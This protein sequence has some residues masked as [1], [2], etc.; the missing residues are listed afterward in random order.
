MYTP[1]DW[2]IESIRRYGL[3]DTED[4]RS[5]W[6]YDTS[7]QKSTLVTEFDLVCNRKEQTDICQSI[8]MLGILIGSVIFGP[9]G[10]RIGRRPV[11]LISILLMFSFGFGAA[12]VEDFYVFMVLRCLVGFATA[13]ILINNLVLVAEWV[14]PSQRAYATITGHVC[15]AVGLMVLAGMGYALRNW[16]L[17]QIA[18]SA[19]SALLVFYIW[20]LPESPRWLLAKGKNEKAKELLQKA[21]HMNKRVLSEDVLQQLQEEKQTKSGNMIDLFRTPTLRKHTLIMCLV[22]FVNA[23][24]YYGLSLSVGNFG[25]DIYLTQL[26]FGAV[27]IPAR[28]GSMFSVQF[29][30]RKLSQAIYLLLGGT[31]CLIIIAI[32]EKLSI[33]ITVL[34]VIGKFA[35]ASSYSVCYIYAA[36]LFPTVIRQNGVG[37]CSMTSRL[38]GIMAPLISI[39]EKYHPAIPMAVYGSGP[40]I[41]GL[42]CFFLPETQG[43]DLQDHTFEDNDIP[44][45]N[46]LPKS[47]LLSDSQTL[48]EGPDEKS[49]RL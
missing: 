27:E 43:R 32:P 4:C 24:V 1:V 26:I 14:G 12:F 21:A 33:V 34:A 30:G 20:L 6:V 18:C 10:D 49:T 23:L 46:G 5:G 31:A 29:F 28:L 7:Q 38:A 25:F 40:I 35:T 11:I 13:G 41:G 9:L 36:E 17:L 2:D 44:R 3:N 48:H 39:L 16:R 45:S 42:L 8:Y 22:W 37:L 47:Q 15:F 19:P